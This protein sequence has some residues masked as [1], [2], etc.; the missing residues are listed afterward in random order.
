MSGV[1]LHPDKIF[2][3]VDDA[4]LFCNL[5]VNKN[6]AL[7]NKKI[8]NLAVG[9]NSN[10]RIFNTA[11][12]EIMTGEYEY[13]FVGWT[14]FPR[15]IFY[16]DAP[17]NRQTVMINPHTDKGFAVDIPDIDKKTF[18]KILFMLHNDYMYLKDFEND[19]NILSQ[20]AEHNNTKVFFIESSGDGTLS[21]RFSGANQNWLTFDDSLYSMRID[22]GSDGDHPGRNSQHVFADFLNKQLTQLL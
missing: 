11:A 15:F 1:G 2:D 4:G 22:Y 20:L 3:M 18:T 14:S 17:K 16:P 12:K 5:L 8:V 13:V 10:E 21:K 9:G 6:P 19:L 7:Q